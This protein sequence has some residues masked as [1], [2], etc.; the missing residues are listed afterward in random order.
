MTATREFEPALTG[1]EWTGAEP[2]MRRDGW[3]IYHSPPRDGES[4][5]SWLCIQDPGEPLGTTIRPEH[6]HAV[7]ALALHGQTFGFTWADVDR[8]GALCL[9]IADDD[10][11]AALADTAARIAALLSPREDAFVAM[12]PGGNED[13]SAYVGPTGTPEG[14]AAF[15]RWLTSPPPAA[16]E[17]ARPLDAPPPGPPHE[18]AG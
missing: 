17:T 7:A 13:G 10:R 8:I 18:D 6:R 12:Y 5:G 1:E 15:A 9:G 4:A 3:L 14:R 16:D 2:A 11:R